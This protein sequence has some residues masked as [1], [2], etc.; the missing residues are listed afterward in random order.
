MYTENGQFSSDAI[1]RVQ[2]AIFAKAYG[3][4]HLLNQLSESNDNNIRNII[5]AMLKAAPTV[6]KNKPWYSAEGVLFLSYFSGRI[7]CGEDDYLFTRSGERS[8]ILLERNLFVR[9][10]FRNPSSVKDV[11]AFLTRTSV[12]PGKFTNLSTVFAN[13]S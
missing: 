8:I 5:N 9:E 6:A 3:D 10:S 11:M 13:A 1:R 7:R 2:N 12:I 4:D